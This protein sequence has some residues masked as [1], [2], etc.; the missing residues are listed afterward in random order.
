MPSR[1]RGRTLRSAGGA[2]QPRQATDHDTTSEESLMSRLTSWLRPS[3]V[4]SAHCDIPCGIYDPA[5]AVQAARTVARMVELIGQIP[6][7]STA[8]ADRNKFVRCVAV[9]EQH[10]E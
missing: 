9:K 4:A 10:A 6:E 5:E 8:V 7:G 3:T 2:A 1:P